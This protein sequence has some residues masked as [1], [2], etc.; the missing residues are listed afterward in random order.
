MEYDVWRLRQIKKNKLYC[1]LWL[2]RFMSEW[3]KNLSKT[4]HKHKLKKNL[5]EILYLKKF[6]ER[7]I[8]KTLDCLKPFICKGSKLN[9]WFVILKILTNTVTSPGTS[10]VGFSYCD[11]GKNNLDQNVSPDSIPSGPSVSLSILVPSTSS[12][13][14][15]FLP[16]CH[17]H[18]AESAAMSQFKRQF[19]LSYL[20]AHPWRS[21]AGWHQRL[22][23]ADEFIWL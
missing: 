23:E 14:I 8:K 17:L 13:Y 4:L 15:K 7:E 3:K 18:S 9:I 20:S 19:T 11:W 1:L 10:V 6:R 5:S 16:F 21:E 22:E 12:L 2:K